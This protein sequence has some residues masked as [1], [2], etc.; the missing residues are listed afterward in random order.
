MGGHTVGLLCGQRV[1]DPADGNLVELSD[2]RI[3]AGVLMAPPGRGEDLAPFAKEHYP[4]LGTTD[5]STMT[6]PALIVLGENDWNA[7]FS[8]RKDWRADAYFLSP[9]PKSMLMLHEAEHG[10]GGGVRVR[11]G[12]DD[13]REPRAGGRAEGAR[14]GLPPHR[15]PPRRRRMVRGD[16]RP[17]ERARPDGHDRI[18]VTL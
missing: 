15:S 2:D 12:G 16:H 7:A 17:A 3:K 5:F 18:E 14:L 13:R 1:T 6:T 9:G 4:I 10:L 8:E 11:R